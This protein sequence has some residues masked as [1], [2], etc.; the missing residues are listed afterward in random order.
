MGVHPVLTHVPPRCPC[1]IRATVQPWSAS[2]WASG[3]PAWPDPI[4]I[5]SN[6]V[7]GL[8][9]RWSRLG[10]PHAATLG[11]TRHERGFHA[12]GY[13]RDDR[14][15]PES[16][17]TRSDSRFV[18]GA[19]RPLSPFAPRKQRRIRA[20]FAERKAT[21][22][23]PFRNRNCF[24]STLRTVNSSAVVNSRTHRHDAPK[25]IM[26]SRIRESLTL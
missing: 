5:A 25:E 10:S 16:L 21:I 3:L 22:H 13:A 9:L 11:P 2:F 4:T 7:I 1:S 18:S 17:A 8:W 14:T 24:V 23:I 6:F 19:E 15:S 20:T 26:A 12:L